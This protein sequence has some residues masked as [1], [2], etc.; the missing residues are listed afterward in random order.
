MA[1]SD[2]PTVFESNNEIEGNL[3]LGYLR[4]EG[5]RAVLVVRESILYLSAV[6]SDRFKIKVPP[7]QADEAVSL[8]KRAEYEKP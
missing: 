5:I 4:K 2:W 7:D 1:E 3:A 6:T 8:L